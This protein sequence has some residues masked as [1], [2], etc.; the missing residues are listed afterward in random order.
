MKTRIKSVTILGRLWHDKI[1]GNTYHSARVFVDGVC[2][3]AVPF[4]YGYGNQFEWNAIDALEAT[5]KF[6]GKSARRVDA[7]RQRCEPGW[8]WIRDRLGVNYL[9]DSTSV[10]KRECVQWGV[11]N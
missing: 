1:N 6:K 4:Q 9:V 7:E 5:G 8:Q 11:R 2:V 3:A 10:S